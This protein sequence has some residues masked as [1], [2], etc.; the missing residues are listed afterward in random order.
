MALASRRC[1]RDAR[2]ESGALLELLGAHKLRLLLLLC[3]CFEIKTMLLCFFFEIKTMLL[4]VF[5]SFSVMF[6]NSLFVAVLSDCYIVNISKH[7]SLNQ[8]SGLVLPTLLRLL[9]ELR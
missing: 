6:V 5:F 4:R 3:V 9:S 8:M 7:T 1:A 2:F